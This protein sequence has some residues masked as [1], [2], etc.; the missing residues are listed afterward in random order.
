MQ[1]QQP[2]QTKKRRKLTSAA[3]KA[4]LRAALVAICSVGVLGTTVYG[5]TRLMNSPNAGAPAAE[6]Q[7]VSTGVKVM[8]GAELSQMLSTRVATLS[9]M[10]TAETNLPGMENTSTGVTTADS[11]SQAAQP[12]DANSSSASSTAEV[13]AVAKFDPNTVG[14]SGASN[15]PAWKAVNADV[16]GW[17]RVPNT[18][19][20]HPVVW[21]ASNLYY[22][23]LDYYK[24]YSKNGVIWA[25]QDTKFGNRSQISQNTVIYG[26][27]WTNYSANPKIGDPNDIMFGQLTAFHHL[28]FAKTTPYIHYSTESE[29]MVW[30]VFA[31]F[32]TEESFNYIISDPGT[33]GLQNIINEAK[34]R[35]V[36]KYDVE[37]D[38]SVDKILTLSTCTRAYGSTSEQ[39]FVVMARLMRAGETTTEYSITA[40]PNHKKPQ[41]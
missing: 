36:H 10:A 31:V 16:R 17:L 37:V 19:I 11:T 15:I 22:N 39:R 38:A 21:N 32:Y 27:N 13:A 5:A 7:S 9:T 30:K 4:Y 1:N 18:N 24:N 29:E 20:N 35:S 14:G 33:A 26:H 23:N 8:E 34:L 41:I 28:D 6:P 40:N 2:K 3:K 25:D 12:Q